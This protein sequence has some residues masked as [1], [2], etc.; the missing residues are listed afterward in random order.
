METKRKRCGISLGYIKTYYKAIAVKRKKTVN[1]I[2]DTYTQGKG[3]KLTKSLIYVGKLHTSMQYHKFKWW[4]TTW[5]VVFNKLTHVNINWIPTI[6]HTKMDYK[7]K[8]KN[9]YINWVQHL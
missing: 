8:H 7:S 2:I 4:S 1:A 9:I 6:P 5:K 3:K